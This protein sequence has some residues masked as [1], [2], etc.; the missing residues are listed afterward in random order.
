MSQHVAIVAI[1]RNEG[2]RLRRC[3][4]SAV[5]QADTLVYVDSGSTDNSVE[6]AAGVGC[7]VVN[8]DQSTPFTAARARN[9]GFQKIHELKADIE[10][11]Q[12]VDG[13]CEIQPTWI[14]T[15]EEFLRKNPK[16]AAVCG[17]RRERY[18]EQS[19]YN[20]LC[21]WEWSVSEGPAKYCGGDVMMRTDALAQV[22]GYRDSLIAGEEPELC[23]RLRA[24]EWG[25]YALQQEMTL[26]DAAME[27]FN[28]WWKRSKRSG[29]AYAAGA[30][31]HGRSEE[32]HWVWECIRCWCWGGGIPLAS[33][34][35]VLLFGSIGWG[36]LL[37]YPLQVLRLSLRG[38]G[39]SKERLQEALFNTLSRFP[40]FQG[41]LT[42]LRD[43]LTGQSQLIE[44]K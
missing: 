29:Y 23:V 27:R 19:I 36:L 14:T 3:L 42:F 7:H 41:Q 38:S 26:H 4:R 34:V 17:R 33:I 43:L 31:L 35:L 22:G 18:P 9:A 25:I 39:S 6:F 8:L 32:R 30:W 16:I 21:D 20:Q 5:E 1:G 40:E 24:A 11:V 2:E 12:F 13:D 15:A 28:Q 37:I 10:F 44:Y